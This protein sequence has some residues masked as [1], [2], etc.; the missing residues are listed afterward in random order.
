L[1]IRYAF[2]WSHEAR[3]GAIEAAK[4][5]PCAIVVATRRSQSNALDV[6]VAP[7]T[8]T[9]NDDKDSLKIPRDIAQALKL[10]DE[11]HWVRLDEIN[12]FSWPGYDLRPIPS[13]PGEYAYGLLPEPF[14]NTLRQALVD[15][16]TA[17]KPKIQKRD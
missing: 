14:F 9:P 12:V 10:D 4:D 15:R 5:R 7:I 13:R 8:H 6:V 1:V 3:T 16:R 2:L 17:V 11:Q